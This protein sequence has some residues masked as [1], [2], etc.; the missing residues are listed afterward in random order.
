ML[1]E[2]TPSN[3]NGTDTRRTGST[4]YLRGMAAADFPTMH[5]APLTKARQRA[6]ECSRPAATVDLPLAQANGTVLAA[7]LTALNDLPA[8]DSSSMDGWAVA[9]AEPWLV[10]QLVLAGH[11]GS[12]IEPGQAAEV[13]T[14][15]QLPYGTEAVVRR[16]HG[17]LRAGRLE[18]RSNTPLLG[19]GRDIRR[20]AEEARRGE[21][22]LPIGTVVT[23]PVLGLAAAAGADSLTVV[24]APVVDVFVMGDELLTSGTAR[25]G[26]VRD[27]LSLQAPWW[28]RALGANAGLV[29]PVPDTESAAVAALA[30]SDADIIVTTG[31]TA[32]GPVDQLHSTLSALH[33]ELAIDRVAVRPGHP[34]LLAVLS[35][36]QPVLGLPGN[37]LAA[38]VCLVSLGLPLVAG[39]RGLPFPARSTASLR[40]PVSAP[41]GVT[42]LL[43]SV[44]QGDGSV[45]PLAQHGP[46]MLSGLARADTIAVIPPGGAPA[47]SSIEVF[48]LPWD[49]HPKLA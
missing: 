21:D 18:R 27:S 44:L 13:A 49:Q 24:P 3:A 41:N 8:F 7:P 38:V 30:A 1:S 34:T 42:R 15:A 48:F 37:P 16:E 10:T 39:A 22:L 17:Q 26:R 2:R 19:P 5:D 29:L 28:V 40:R 45:L 9:G 12:A 33:A 14:G 20:R 32:H 47:D 36:G 6:Y 35:S 31:G 11:V 4:G 25:N 46:A 43:P 23:A